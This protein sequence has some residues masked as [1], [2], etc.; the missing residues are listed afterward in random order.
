MLAFQPCF[1][2]KPINS[3]SWPGPVD[4]VSWQ[5]R[6]SGH[7]GLQSSEPKHTVLW[8]RGIFPQGKHPNI[9][10]HNQSLSLL[11]NRSLHTS[12]VVQSQ[13]LAY[14]SLLKLTEND[15][16]RCSTVWMLICTPDL[17]QYPL[18]SEL[19]PSIL[20]SLKQ[21]CLTVW[22][23]HDNLCITTTTFFFVIQQKSTRWKTLCSNHTALESIVDKSIV[24]ID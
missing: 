21:L 11:H 16:N 6:V 13:K 19:S 9:C 18:L 17:K 20:D 15:L 3:Y 24:R 14:Y 8:R 1:V 10:A 22:L 5:T 2:L 7:C 23:W 4:K 12:H